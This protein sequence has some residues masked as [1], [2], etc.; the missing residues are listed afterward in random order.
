M[1]KHLALIIEHDDPERVGLIATYD[2]RPSRLIKNEPSPI[3]VLDED[4]QGFAT[5]GKKVGLGYVDFEG[6]DD[7]EENV[8]DE[9]ERKLADIDA[10]WL[11]KAGVELEE[12]TA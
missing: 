2:S 10:K 3:Q 12:P 1:R 9:A 6:E 4:K 7:Y 5:V 8:F 11:D